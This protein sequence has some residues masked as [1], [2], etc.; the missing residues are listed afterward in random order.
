MDSIPYDQIVLFG[1]LLLLSGYFSA[2]ETAITSV[3]RIRLRHQS[4]DSNNKA[5][6]SLHLAE[7]FDQSISTILI[8]NNIVNIVIAALA[9]KFATDIY[10]STGSTVAI[11]T[12]I[13]IVLI[14]VFGEILPKTLVKPYAQKYI[15]VMSLP[16]TIMMKLFYPLTWL[17]G[18]LKAGI[19]QL[20]GSKQGE[21]TVTE[22][23]LKALVQIGEEE[24]TFHSQEKELVH[25]ALEFN[26]IIVNDILT[27]RPYVVAVPLTASNEEIKNTFIEKQFSRLPIYDGSIDNVIGTISNR[28]FFAKYV[29]D[30]QFNIHDIIRKPHFVV[31]S[32]KIA[33][34]LKELQQQKIHLAIV[35]DEYGGTAGI[36][37]IEDIVEELV[38]EIW[39]E[40]DQN[41][42]LIERITDFKIRLDGRVSIEEM[43]ELLNISEPETSANTLSGWILE[44]LGHLPQK[45]E[46]LEYLNHTFLV[47]EVRSRRIQTVVVETQPIVWQSEDE[48]VHIA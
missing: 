10:G 18:Q 44:I 34:L 2:S 1:L 28:D 9:T 11:S 32:M 35:L 15:L 22:E 33:K 20:L 37:S 3:N 41:D 4:E 29:S 21:P 19:N 6:R 17:F 47:E 46:V 8:G 40:F 24:G 14:L 45:G 42:I 7:K 26:S 38:G 30:P 31:G 13:V 27:P 25:S 16:L 43:C 36:I 5:I 23:D 39:D 12:I 48:A